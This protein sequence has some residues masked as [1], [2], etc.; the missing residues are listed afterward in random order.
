MP[1]SNFLPSPNL[2]FPLFFLSFSSNSFP[3]L[4]TPLPG[5]LHPVL[6]FLPQIILKCPTWKT[7]GFVIGRRKPQLDLC[8]ENPHFQQIQVLA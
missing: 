8:T 2:L 1:L 7:N 6:T 3:N 4:K 5:Y